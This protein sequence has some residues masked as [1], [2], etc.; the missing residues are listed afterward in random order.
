VPNTQ[1]DV[2]AFQQSVSNPTGLTDFRNMPDYQEYGRYE[3][4]GVLQNFL[5]R[6]QFGG[7]NP[8]VYTNNPAM[9]GV[10]DAEMIALNPGIQGLEPSIAANIMNTSD[11]LQTNMPVRDMSNDPEEMIVQGQQSHQIKKTYEPEGDVTLDFKTKAAVDPQ[12]YLLTGNAAARG[13]LGMID[14]FQNRRR[15]RE[16]YN[17]LTSDNLYAGDTSRDRGDY[18]TNSGLYRPDEMGQTWNSRSKQ[19]GGQND[20]L[21]E[22]PDYVDGDE[23]Y[24]TEDQIQDFLARGGEIEYI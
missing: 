18:D 12:A 17:N 10:S 21:N 14:R 4:G 6:A 15:E 3:D 22:D 5:L 11:L 7:T 20:Y 23:V 2:K 19:F 1:A 9:A 16:M 13:A 8:V 24:M